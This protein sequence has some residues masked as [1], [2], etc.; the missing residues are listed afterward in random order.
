MYGSSCWAE[1]PGANVSIRFAGVLRTTS[2]P[3]QLAHQLTVL[4][5]DFTS[6]VRMLTKNKLVSL[7]FSYSP[8]APIGSPLIRYPNSINT[9]TLAHVWLSKF[10]VLGWSW[11]SIILPTCPILSRFHYF[12]WTLLLSHAIYWHIVMHHWLKWIWQK[13]WS[14]IIFSARRTLSNTV[15]H[16]NWA[17]SWFFGNIN[18]WNWLIG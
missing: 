4:R 8:I 3:H 10:Q 16:P 7:K 13:E 11:P 17:S 2:W 9:I 5:M 12:Q 18:S 15:N 6:R 14:R 1:P